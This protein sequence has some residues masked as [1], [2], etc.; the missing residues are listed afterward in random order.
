M[1]EMKIR[2]IALVA[3]QLGLVMMS[4]HHLSGMAESRQT[5][6]V[7]DFVFAECLHHPPMISEVLTET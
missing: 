3:I 2:R 1:G 6:A 7:K 5:L 4:N